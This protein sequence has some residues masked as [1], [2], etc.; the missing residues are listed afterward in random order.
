MIEA[1]ALLLHA[2]LVIT[3]VMAFPHPADSLLVGRM[4]RINER[5]LALVV[6]AVG[7]D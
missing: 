7:L 6:G 4:L 5:F 2:I 3:D 1:S